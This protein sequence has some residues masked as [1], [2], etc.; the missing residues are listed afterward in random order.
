MR[1]LHWHLNFDEW[2]YVIN[3]SWAAQPWL[4]QTVEHNTWPGST[5]CC[6]WA[7]SRPVGCSYTVLPPHT[8]ATQA[9]QSAFLTHQPHDLVCLAPCLQGTLEVGVFLA[10]GESAHGVIGA[11]DL[12]FAPQ[13]SG[14]YLRN[15]GDEMAY[16]VLIFNSG[17]FTNVDIN[18]FLGVFP[19]SWVAA[20]LDISTREAEEINYNLPGFAPAQH[21]EPGPQ[22]PAGP[23][24]YPAGPHP[25]PGPQHHQV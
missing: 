21:P 10:P 2:Q 20:S 16:V 1:Q 9:L 19:P 22:H 11:G 4:F 14:H 5:V 17:E 23:G 7:A 15:I 18:N 6:V 12:G 3:V 24:P 13:G 8:T 25:G